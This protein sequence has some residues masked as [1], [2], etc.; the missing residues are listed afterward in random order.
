MKSQ[1][2]PLKWVGV[3]SVIVG[4]SGAFAFD[5]NNHPFESVYFNRFVGGT[6]GAFRKFEMDYWGNCI[7]KSLDWV[8]TVEPARKKTV[9]LSFG[10]L[11]AHYQPLFPELK[12]VD[13]QTPHEFFVKVL[14]AYSHETLNEII[15]TPSI[16]HTV[17]TRDGTPLCIVSR[18]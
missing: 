18:E 17:T 10:H 8:A 16:V 7:R 3:G 13:S 15:E 11:G 1:F 14:R 5:W 12:F 2:K 4:L 6:R 9:A